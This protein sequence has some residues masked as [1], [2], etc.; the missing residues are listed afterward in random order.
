MVMFAAGV[1]AISKH[2]PPEGNCAGG[3]TQKHRGF[4]RTALTKKSDLNFDHS[5]LFSVIAKPGP[6]HNG[7]TDDVIKVCLRVSSRQ[8][9]QVRTACPRC[10]RP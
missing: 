9:R 3:Y 6:S 10:R 5:H 4:S 1:Y 8:L 7:Q 2:A